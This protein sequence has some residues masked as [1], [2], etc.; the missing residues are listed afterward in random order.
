MAARNAAAS[1]QIVHS[2]AK[3]DFRLS[4]GIFVAGVA[5]VLATS[6]FSLW[7]NSTGNYPTSLGGGLTVYLIGTAGAMMVLLGG[8]VAFYHWRFLRQN[9]PYG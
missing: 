3:R 4:L 2:I 7:A 5:M 9:W 8:T 1:D 6:A